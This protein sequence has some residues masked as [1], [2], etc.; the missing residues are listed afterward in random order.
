MAID[1]L[2]AIQI[3]GATQWIRVRGADESNPVLLLIQIGPGLPM[4]NEVRRFQRLLRL[5][6]D[7]TVVYWD[8]R[9]CGRSLRSKLP[10]ADI[11][12]PNMVSDTVA[13]LEMLNDR[14]GA[15][16]CVVGFSMGATV[17]AY[18]AAQRPDLVATLVTV[19]LDIDGVAAGTSAYEFALDTARRRGNRR[20]IRQLEGIGPPPHLQQKQFATRARWAMNFG[21]VASHETRGSMTRELLSSLV[22]SRDYSVADTVR[23][24]RGMTATQ[25]ALLRDS[26]DIDLVHTLPRIDVPV[27]MVQ[28]RLDRVAPTDV[29]ERYASSLSAPSKRWVWFE[30]SAHLPHLEEPGKFRE[31]LMQVRAGLLVPVSER[32][33][34]SQS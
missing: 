13:L 11:T 22:R 34:A 19:G 8:Q 25:T 29:A 28:G 14:F 16:T 27:V 30:H 12:L 33:R 17:G 5:E 21:G 4:L 32:R 23:T 2:E 26:A 10:P 20:A 3:G 18:A 15:T 31:V 1:S 9:G 24:V 6:H 7:F